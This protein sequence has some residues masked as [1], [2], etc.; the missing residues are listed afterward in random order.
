[1]EFVIG[2]FLFVVLIVGF[3][4][5]KIKTNQ[6]KHKEFYRNRL[7]TLKSGF[8]KYYKYTDYVIGCDAFS[9]VAINRYDRTICLA[10]ID[11][12]G[13]HINTYASNNL[14]S[15]ERLEEEFSFGE[16][17][18]LRITV[19]DFNKPVHEIHFNYGSIADD[20]LERMKIRDNSRQLLYQWYGMLNIIISNAEGS[21]Y[22]FGHQDLSCT[23]ADKPSQSSPQLLTQ[24]CARIIQ[25]E[26]LI[27]NM[28]KK[29]NPD[30]MYQ[31]ARRY[32]KGEG[33]IQ[34]DHIAAML[35]LQAAEQG[36]GFAQAFLGAMLVEGRGMPKDTMHAY[37]WLSL[38]S[39]QGIKI[40]ISA[41]E[42]LI[43]GMTAAQFAEA[44]ELLR[45]YLTAAG[46]HSVMPAIQRLD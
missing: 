18:I 27:E 16:K 13:L 36:H 26:K 11:T 5:D 8:E 29:E 42:T 15:I 17:A 32:L 43:K 6:N 19:T 33:V 4:A 30:D 23:T 14:V 40:A 37:I 24:E 44:E 28:T 31:S 12:R 35:F 38:S 22:G 34:D 39:A 3:L 46:A 25:D 21:E 10:Y 9:G 41:R 2:F 1:M 45:V 20:F 7:A